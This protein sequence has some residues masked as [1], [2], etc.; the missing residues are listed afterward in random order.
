MNYLRY[1]RCVVEEYTLDKAF[2]LSQQKWMITETAKSLDKT[3]TEVLLASIGFKSKED[4]V[5]MG[6]ALV[7][8]AYSIRTC[9]I[10]STLFWEGLETYT[11]ETYNELKSLAGD[12]SKVEEYKARIVDYFNSKVMYYEGED[13]AVFCPSGE[14]YILETVPA[15][16]LLRSVLLRGVDSGF[17]IMLCR[18]WLNDNTE[19]YLEYIQQSSSSEVVRQFN[20]ILYALGVSAKDVSKFLIPVDRYLDSKHVMCQMD[21]TFTVM[22]PLESFDKPVSNIILKTNTL[23]GLYASCRLQ[24]IKYT[25]RRDHRVYVAE[26]SDGSSVESYVRA[27]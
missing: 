21:N 7:D 19:S 22:L 10:V 13:L 24:D 3:V 17:G 11:P 12:S 27:L 6:R 4:L 23:E 16:T 25:L 5:S 15:D 1:C 26:F 9:D 14:L 8:D 20:A 18:N 2:E